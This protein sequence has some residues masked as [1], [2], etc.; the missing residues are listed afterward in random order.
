MGTRIWVASMPRCLCLH[1]MFS[2]CGLL[3]LSLLCMVPY[4]HACCMF[5]A[6]Q[7][8]QTTRTRCVAHIL[9]STMGW[10]AGMVTRGGRCGAR[11]HG[12][13]WHGMSWGIRRAMAW[14]DMC[15]RRCPWYASC[16]SSEYMALSGVHQ[17]GA[18][19]NVQMQHEVATFSR[20]PLVS[21]SCAGE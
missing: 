14:H 21:P 4:R 1:V 2:G 7:S 13:A 5:R 11:Q 3:R 6:L 8:A 9:H 19:V 10:R 17:E 18:V 12:M 20:I 16:S 15:C